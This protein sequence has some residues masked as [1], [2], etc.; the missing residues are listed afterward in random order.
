MCRCRA[1]PGLENPVP[2]HPHRFDPLGRRGGDRDH[3]LAGIIVFGDQARTNEMQRLHVL[4]RLAQRRLDVEQEMAHIGERA[5]HDLR[6]D[7]GLVRRR[8]GM[9]KAN[10]F[11]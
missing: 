6:E 1:P 7:D 4:S 3:R 8:C 9:V 2:D 5:L 10:L 11:R